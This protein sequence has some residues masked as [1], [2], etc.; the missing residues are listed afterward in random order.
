MKSV[1]LIIYP[2]WIVPVIPSKITLENH[3][4]VV[5]QGQIIDILP[6]AETKQ[7][8]QAAE[9][10]FLPDQVVLPGF[11]NSHTHLPM[12]LFKSVANDLPLMDWLQNHLWPLEAKWLSEEFVYDAVYLGI[13]EMIRTGTVCFNDFY[14][15]AETIYK[16]VKEIGIRA[17]IGIGILD[18]E[19]TWSSSADDAINKALRLINTV[20]SNDLIS[21][22]FAP[23]APYTVSDETLNKIKTE[24]RKLDLDIQ[25]HV[26][27]TK[28]EVAQSMKDYGIRP[29][30]RL[31]RLDLLSPK[32]NCIHMANMNE[33]DIE[34]LKN[35][36]ANVVH[37]PESN[38]KLVSGICPVNTLLRQGINVSLGTDSVASNN[39]L[40]MIGEMRTASLLA[41]G[42]TGDPTALNAA[43]TLQMATLNAAKT[44]GISQQIGSIEKNKS[45]DIISIDLHDICSQPT[46]EI[47]PQIVYAVDRKQV[48]N[49]WIAGKQ[50]L[51]DKQFTTIDEEKI[52]VLAKKWRE[53]ILT[54]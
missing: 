45:A 48:A 17:R 28:V 31:R 34:T 25:M 49:V 53:K 24:A 15:F 18:T 35:S 50:M 12:S 7:K 4:I 38:L 19:T 52:I 16:A 47:I 2:S 54:Q 9:T 3:A 39:D 10:V 14:F 46:Y 30:E 1:D 32:F 44:L 41:K 26:H 21:F 22:D 5:N 33:Q 13:A 27:E 43:E 37:C 40:D 11:I 20:G 36:K 42:I 51:R 6:T 29:L 23:H 8:Y